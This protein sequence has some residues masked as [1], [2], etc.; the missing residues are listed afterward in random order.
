VNVVRE[1]PKR[2][3]LLFAGTE[4]GVFVSF[5]AGGSWQALQNGLPVTS[6][7]D[8]T[9]KNDDVV[10]AT[11]GRGFYV[12]DDIAPLR[13]A[14]AETARAGAHLYAPSTAYRVRPAGFTGTPMPKDEPMAPNPPLGAAVDYVLTGAPKGPVTLTIR[15]A[16]GTVVRRYESD[17]R[18]PPPGRRERVLAP[19][20]IST[21]V[22]LPA[23]PGMHR[24]VWSI[25]HAAPPA[26]G[27]GSAFADGVWAVPGRYTVEL[28]VD[29]KTM[30]QP[31]TVAPDPRVT[32]APETY[33]RQHELALRAEAA[34]EKIA[35]ATS[36]AEA[37]HKQLAER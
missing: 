5:D 30:T 8:M 33:A 7:R 23:T 32:M 9:V 4:K 18:V 11:H 3:G 14:T 22:A 27:H 2:K 20:W 17:D 25:R 15:D 1:D 26:L 24:Y 36:E 12:L 19:E 21:P 35:A 34:A 28:A 31:L 6:V 29:G 10:V 16:K 37:L 13:Q